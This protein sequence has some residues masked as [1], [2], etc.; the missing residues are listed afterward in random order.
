MFPRPFIDV[1]GFSVNLYVLFHGLGYVPAVYLGL[2]L[3]RERGYPLRPIAI[4]CILAVVGALVVG[5]AIVMMVRPIAPRVPHT[6]ALAQLVGAMLAIWAYILPRPRPLIGGLMAMGDILFPPLVLYIAVA[7]LGCFSA[8][9][10][11]GDPA[12]GVPWAVIFKD[13]ASACI[14]EGIPVHPTQLYETLGCLI[15]FGVLMT[16][17]NRSAWRGGLGWIF[18]FGYGT[19]RFLIEF[20]RGEVRQ[21][22]GPLSLTQVFCMGMIVLGGI[23]LV[24]RFNHSANRVALSLGRT[25]P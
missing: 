21:M 20:Y 1:F 8:G 2:W 12:W 19:L 7:R 9:C 22:V 25:T 24:R 13:P 5:P 17:R 23:M 4:C 3:A 11:H 16:L 14:F 18:L 10:C 6:F 15:L